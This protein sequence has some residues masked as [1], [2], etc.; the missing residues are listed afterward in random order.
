METKLKKFERLEVIEVDYSDLNDLVHRVYG[1]KDYEF[2]ADE[3]M[4]NDST[5]LYRDVGREGV[6]SYEEEKLEKFKKGGI[7]TYITRTLLEDMCRSGH[8][9]P[10]NYLI[11]V[12]W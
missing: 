5:K 9:E 10:G 7:E 11:S 4:N 12:C 2:V 8:L 6:D 1:N 3:E